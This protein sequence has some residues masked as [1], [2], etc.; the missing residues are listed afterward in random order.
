MFQ[1]SGILLVYHHFNLITPPLSSH[2]F[3][4][5][6]NK[7]VRMGSGLRHLQS[8]RILI[9]FICIILSTN[10]VLVYMFFD[11]PDSQTL[12][13]IIPQLLC[14]SSLQAFLLKHRLIYSLDFEVC[15]RYSVATPHILFHLAFTEIYAPP[16]KWDF[17]IR[18]QII[19]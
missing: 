3:A 1:I 8:S 17:K 15:E 18:S 12:Y 9:Q 6:R 2:Q 10:D 5:T 19:I 11:Y 14:A 13:I 7:T 16:D 4:E